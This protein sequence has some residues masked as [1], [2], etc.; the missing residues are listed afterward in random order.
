[1]SFTFSS[2]CCLAGIQDGLASGT[3]SPP[4]LKRKLNDGVD[5]TVCFDLA[6]VQ[7][8]LNFTRQEL[9]D[10]RMQH[11]ELH[12]LCHNTLLSISPA[13]T[14]KMRAQE[15]EGPA[16]TAP[17]HKRQDLVPHQVRDLPVLKTQLPWM[18]GTKSPITP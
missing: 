14:P 16:M 9:Q 11:A 10:L 7:Q 1:M 12:Q 17:K 13:M 2:S 5:S 15:L 18:S 3:G 4:K 8:E 6:G